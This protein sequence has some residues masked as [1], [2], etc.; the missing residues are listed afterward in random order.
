MLNTATSI[1][2]VIIFFIAIQTK[3]ASHLQKKGKI[4]H[5]LRAT[6]TWQ[7]VQV[8]IKPVKNR[9]CYVRAASIK[10]CIK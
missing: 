5:D 7:T 4:L 1:L 10:I 9:H 8:K 6:K 3:M 2:S